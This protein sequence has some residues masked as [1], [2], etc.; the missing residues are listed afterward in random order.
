[1]AARS[2][3]ARIDD[4]YASRSYAT[5]RGGT[6][7]DDDGRV[8]ADDDVNAK[9]AGELQGSLEAA[10]VVEVEVGDDDDDDAGAGAN[11]RRPNW[12]E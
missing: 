2:A 1:M 5:L 8:L 12:S 11:E 6:T 7:V 9:N 4:A 3:H 10:R